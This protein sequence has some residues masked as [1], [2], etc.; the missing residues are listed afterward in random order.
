[1]AGVAAVFFWCC[2]TASVC[3]S[4]LTATWYPV[5]DQEYSLGRSE[6]LKTAVL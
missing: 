6:L 5:P 1:M 3:V 2:I 4:H